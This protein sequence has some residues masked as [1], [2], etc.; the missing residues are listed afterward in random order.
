VSRLKRVHLGCLDQYRTGI[1]RWR[2]GY[3]NHHVRQLLFPPIPRLGFYSSSIHLRFLSPATG[4]ASSSN[5]ERSI[6]SLTTCSYPPTGCQRSRAP[7][8]PVSLCGSSLSLPRVSR[9]GP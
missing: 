5:S 9:F 1:R 2:F 6:R 7:H 3:N 8:R 4:P